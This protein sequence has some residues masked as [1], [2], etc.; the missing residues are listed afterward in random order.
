MSNQ[1]EQVSA[2][3]IARAAERAAD[4]AFADGDDAKAARLY[5]AAGTAYRAAGM[6]GSA[7]IVLDAAT[8]CQRFAG[9]R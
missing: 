1:Q 5:R 4:K 3:E 7:M 2:V 6:P 9:G 8:C